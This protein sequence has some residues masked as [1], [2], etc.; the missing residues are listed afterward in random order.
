MTSS[1]IRIFRETLYPTSVHGALLVDCVAVKCTTVPQMWIF[2][3]FTCIPEY[4]V[5]WTGFIYKLLSGYP[6]VTCRLS[7]R[8]SPFLRLLT[9]SCS[10]DLSGMHKRSRR[11]CRE[12]AVPLFPHPLH[13]FHHHRDCPPVHESVSKCWVAGYGHRWRLYVNSDAR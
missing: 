13:S 2:V 11:R 6:H 8:V 9:V 1:P 4:I 12:A 10:G 7:S 5:K 3:E